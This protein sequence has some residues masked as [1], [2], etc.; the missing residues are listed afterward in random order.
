MHKTPS[1]TSLNA[2]CTETQIQSS[3][4][5]IGAQG[6]LQRP[7]KQELDS[8]FGTTNDAEIVEAI[9]S[10][11]RIQEG[12]DMHGVGAGSERAKDR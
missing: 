8:V 9:L 10:K 2:E 1:N 5:S 6:M 3:Y 11:G 4:F 7:S 12:R